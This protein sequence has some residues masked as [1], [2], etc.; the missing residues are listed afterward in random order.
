MISVV[1]PTVGNVKAVIACLESLTRQAA[2]PNDLEIIIVDN[3]STDD[4]GIALERL[5]DVYL[6][7]SG[8]IGFPRAVNAGLDV[9]EGEYVLIC[10]DD[11]EMMT[12]GWDARLIET[13]ES[14]PNAMMVAPVTD[15][16]Y[17]APQHVAS[18][19]EQ[20]TEVDRL[21]FVCVLAR[22]QD[23]VNLDKLDERFGLGNYEDNDLSLRIRQAG[24]KLLVDPGVFVHHA[25]HGTFKR[26]LSDGEF[27][28]LLE[29]NKQLM[30]D[31]WLT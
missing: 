12:G 20:A 7:F 30:A 29:R 28:A 15:F 21:C 4:E 9:A 8:P 14:W 25:G 24:G 22:R 3:S 23:L 18:C 5:A 26:L 13:L 1:I 6:P 2:A 10:N 16:V 31:K 17:N 19:E 11:T 27:A